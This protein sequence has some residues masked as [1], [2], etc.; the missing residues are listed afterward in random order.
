MG[1]IDKAARIVI[2][3]ILII[4]HLTNVVSG[5]LGIVLLVVAGVFIIT[6][7][8]SFCPLYTI[9]KITTNPKTKPS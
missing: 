7:T 2:A 3:A 1:F 8:I 4:L 9:L 5:T 6:S